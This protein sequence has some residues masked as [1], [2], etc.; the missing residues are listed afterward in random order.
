MSRPYGLPEAI[1]DLAGNVTVSTL[2]V[3][4]AFTNLGSTYHTL[5]FVLHNTSASSNTTMLVET[6]EDGTYA[7]A[8]IKWTV[9]CPPGK[10]ASVEVGPGILRRFWRLSAYSDS[11][12]YPEVAVKWAIRGVHRS[13]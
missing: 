1:T 4:K 9:T 12:S 6:S 13:T 8:H 5:L 2:T 3:L 11:P 7:D 10:Q